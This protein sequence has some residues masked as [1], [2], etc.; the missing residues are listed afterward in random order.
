LQPVEVPI[1]YDH[2]Q[3]TVGHTSGPSRGTVYV[4][5]LDL[6]PKPYDRFGKWQGVG[7]AASHDGGWHFRQ[8]KGVFPNDLGHNTLGAVTLSDGTLIVFFMDYL[9]SR[10]DGATIGSQTMQVGR[11]WVIA[12]AHGGK[13][14]SA[15]HYVAEAFISQDPAQR[16]RLAGF[17]MVAVASSPRSPFRDRLYVV[18]P[19]VRHGA[20]DVWLSSSTDRGD[21]WSA[22]VRVNDNLV[23]K[24]ERGPDQANAAVAVNADGVVGISWYDRRND[25]EGNG[26]QLFFTASLDGGKT[27][28]PNKQ[29]ST[30]LSH[31]DVPGNRIRRRQNYP[32]TIAQAW[33]VGG[34]YSGLTASTDGCF[35][36]IWTDTRTGVYQL[37]TAAIQV[38]A[39]PSYRGD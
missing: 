16:Q 25:P 14:F 38:T 1:G 19:D 10:S 36:A 35:H 13:S 12:S 4:T 5:A 34:D 28:L 18:W 27:F 22:P 3:I 26:W 21:S 39:R 7:V 20:A 31:P 29:V 30:V 9:I 17:P 2:P 24:G 11:I 23:R 37:W 32:E 8:R 15:P 33:P 6:S